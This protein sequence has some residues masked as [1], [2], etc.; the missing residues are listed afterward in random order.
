MA[1]ADLK[2]RD[3]LV[4]EIKWS[5][6]KQAVKHGVPLNN[7]RSYG[8]M[9][10]DLLEGIHDKHGVGSVIL[11]DEYDAPVTKNMSDRN[12]ALAFRDVLHDFYMS[13]KTN[14][15]HVRFAFVTG[16]T[17]FAMASLDSGANSFKDISIDERYAGICGFTS[18]EIDALF[19]D[20]LEATLEAL[21]AMGN[22]QPNAGVDELKS[23]IELWYDGYNWLGNERVFNPYSILNFF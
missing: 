18:R 16:I 4:S 3:D 9:M 21:K 15:E 1:Y 22:L 19:E 5:L 20:R 17:R 10:E 6:Q 12:L 2:V 7:E 14:F 23:Q 11:V 13:I 8:G